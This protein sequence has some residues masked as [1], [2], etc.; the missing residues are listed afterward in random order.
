M[1]RHINGIDLAYDDTGTGLPVL[2]L[3]AFPLHRGMWTGQVRGLAGAAR[4]IVLDL[5]GFGE[6]DATDGA[7]NMDQYADDVRLLLDAVGVESVVLAGLSMGGYIALTFARNH[8][9]HLKGLI[10]ADTRAGPDSAEAAQT[11]R[12][13]ATRAVRE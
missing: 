11:R 5:R 12:E 8:P 9:R 6:S 2:W 7:Y 4:H 3:H 13:N 10:L 1:K